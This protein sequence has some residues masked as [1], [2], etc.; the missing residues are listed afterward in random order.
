[1]KKFVGEKFGDLPFGANIQLKIS[2]ILRAEEK[3]F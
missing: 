3:Q 2:Y 1:L